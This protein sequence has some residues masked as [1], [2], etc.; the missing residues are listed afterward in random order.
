[1]KHVITAPATTADRRLEAVSAAQYSSRTLYF[2][3][4]DDEVEALNVRI[5]RTSAPDGTARDP[6]VAAATLQ[7]DGLWRCYLTPLCFSDV[8]SDLQY[9]LIGVDAQ[10]NPRHLGTGLLRV[11]ESHLTA[12]GTLPDVI[13]ADTYLYNPSTGLYHKLTAEVD[14]QGCI[15]VAVE[16]EGIER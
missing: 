1:M 8:A 16:Q 10:G 4:R 2:N 9:D 3:V 7:Q 6:Y 14:D 13:P 5:F 15:T 11:Q 12:D